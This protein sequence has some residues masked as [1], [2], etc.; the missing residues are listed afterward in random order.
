MFLLPLSLVG[1]NLLSSVLTGECQTRSGEPGECMKEK[2]CEGVVKRRYFPSLCRLPNSRKA[3]IC[4]KIESSTPIPTTTTTTE[5]H[6]EPTTES[7]LRCGQISF[8]TTSDATK[9]K[10]APFAAF[11]E[12]REIVAGEITAHGSQPWIAALGSVMDDD[13]VEF[14]CGGSLVSDNHVLTSAH[15]IPAL[16]SKAVVCIK[17]FI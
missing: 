12:T 17:Y 11:K 13:S 8:T 15:C 14:V 6:T 10:I 3:G 16:G 7:Y 5:R 2:D 1:F 4:C 9:P